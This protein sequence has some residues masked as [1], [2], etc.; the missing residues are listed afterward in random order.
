MTP[1]T[2][3][4]KFPTVT[5][6]L[7]GR[8]LN[9]A[10]LTEGR[11]V[12]FFGLPGAFTPTCSS[13]HVPRYEEL[14]ASFQAVGVDDIVC[15]S[16]NDEFVMKAW[17]RDQGV[18]NVTLL[19]DG[20]GTLTDALGLLVDKDALGFGK[21]SWRYALVVTDGVVTHTF[22]EP[23]RDGD[24]YETSDADTVLEGLGGT[25]PPD[26]VLVG[27]HGCKYCTKARADLTEA[28]IPFDEVQSGPR[29]L[30]AM[31]GRTTTPQIFID[32]VHIGGSDDLSVWLAARS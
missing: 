4:Q 21:R 17:G 8:T 6:N 10:T 20:N 18:K 19:A 32:G 16:V 14:Y 25:R 27:R 26:V 15:I 9:T 7:P 31:S 2:V 29:R 11:T 12:V 1:I 13:S 30:R 24:P 22:I 23:V 5:L 28:G 3:G